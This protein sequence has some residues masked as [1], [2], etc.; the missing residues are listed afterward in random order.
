MCVSGAQ[1]R[2][3]IISCIAIS[4]QVCSAPC[5]CGATQRFQQQ[6]SH[7]TSMPAISVCKRMYGNQA[8]MKARRE[9][10]DRVGVMLA[11]ITHVLAKEAYLLRY[12][13]PVDAD[14]LATGA[15]LPSPAPG[16][17]EHASVGGLDSFVAQQFTRAA[18]RKALPAIEDILLFPGV[19]VALRRD[20]FRYQ[21][22]KLFRRERCSS[23]WIV[24]FHFQS[25]RRGPSSSFSR[26]D[27]SCRASA[28]RPGRCFSRAMEW[29]T[30]SN[31]DLATRA[32]C[33]STMVS[34][35]SRGTMA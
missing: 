29:L 3:V 31:S 33:L 21:A 17:A 25:L 7:Q 16:F 13:C 2:K 22:F 32:A 9:F 5:E 8:M 10:I 19:E 27:F 20:F 6:I 30:L 18:L 24:E 34:I 15:I 14:I 12:S 1:G 23:C 28:S 35:G 4:V 11:L 26:K